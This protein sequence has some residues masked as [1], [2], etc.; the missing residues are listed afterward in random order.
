LFVEYNFLIFGEIRANVALSRVQISLE[1]GGC[2]AAFDRLDFSYVLTEAQINNL[3]IVGLPPQ[4][5]LI[6][7]V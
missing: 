6:G 5:A 4:R 7:Y 1:D 2:S 3:R